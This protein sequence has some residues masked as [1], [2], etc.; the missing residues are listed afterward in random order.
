MVPCFFEDDTGNKVTVTGE[1]YRA[2]IKDFLP[3]EIEQRGLVNMWFQQHG[4]SVHTAG[5][6]MDIMREAFSGRVISRFGD[7]AWPARSPDLKTIVLFLGGT[8]SRG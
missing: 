2:M 4:A 8:S 1:R 3:P 5:A 6:T 7:L